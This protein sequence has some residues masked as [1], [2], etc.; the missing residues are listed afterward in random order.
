MEQLLLLLLLQIKHC[1]AD[2]MVQSYA[3]TVRKGVYRD[4][5]GISHS[6]DHVVATTIALFVFS[7]WHTIPPLTI[8]GIALLEGIAHYHIDWVKVRYGCKDST[9]SAFWAE[10]G[11]DQFAHQLCYILIITYICL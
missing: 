3:Q 8:L 4:L 11:I 7:L 10:F 2:F 9:R 5:V 1:Y 6:L